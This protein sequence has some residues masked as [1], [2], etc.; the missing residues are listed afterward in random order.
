MS[1][2]LERLKPEIDRLSVEE[3]EELANY[4]DSFGE[5]SDESEEAIRAAWKVEIEKRIA[6]C[7]AGQDGAVPYEVVLEEMRRKYRS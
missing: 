4:L 7:N 5:P 3:R 1:L 6:E 2:S